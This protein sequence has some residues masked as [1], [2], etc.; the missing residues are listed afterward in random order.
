M[1]RPGKSSAKQLAGLAGCGRK[2]AST[3]GELASLALPVGPDVVRIASERMRRG[4]RFWA[5]ATTEPPETG[6]RALRRNSQQ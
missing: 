4:K 1:L 3:L 2:R 5:E 6:A